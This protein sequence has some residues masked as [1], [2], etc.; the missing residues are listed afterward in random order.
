MAC[1]NA[2][3]TA[4]Q[5]G[6]PERS[7]SAEHGILAGDAVDEDV[8]PAVIAGDAC[9][10]GLDLGLDGVIDAHG[11]AGAAGGR[12]HRGGL[13]DRLRPAVRRRIAG[14]AAAG[15]VDDG[16]G[17]AERPRDAAPGTACGSGDDGDLSGQWR[18]GWHVRLL[19][20]SV[21]KRSFIYFAIK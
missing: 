17:L 21:Y 2:S 18:L 19:L 7:P 15:A 10:E 5:V 13:V 6:L 20:T 9:E 16:A 12:H 11:D 1:R 14:N 4:R 3:G 8:Q